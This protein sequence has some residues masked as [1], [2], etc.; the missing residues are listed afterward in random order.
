MSSGMRT[1]QKL[2]KA[3]Q[4]ATPNSV[5]EKRSQRSPSLGQ[6]AEAEEENLNGYFHSTV[7]LLHG[8]KAAK[9]NVEAKKRQA[10]SYVGQFVQMID[11][12]AVQAADKAKC[13]DN[14]DSR[15]DADQLASYEK[16]KSTTVELKKK[17][18]DAM[19][20]F[21]AEIGYNVAAGDWANAEPTHGPLSPD[22]KRPGEPSPDKKER[23]TAAA[24][25]IAEAKR[26]IVDLDESAKKCVADIGKH[27]T[28]RIDRTGRASLS[29]VFWYH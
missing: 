23:K 18:L 26:R 28:D 11:D 3:G 17:I 19:G 16:Y 15:V 12:S 14:E 29:R 20:G 21:L 27:A 22:A 7:N 2:A 13:Y 9:T 24:K 25:A 8:L 1:P 10:E 5:R 4:P 6:L